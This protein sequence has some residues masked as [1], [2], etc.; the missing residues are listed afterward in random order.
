MKKLNNKWFVMLG[1]VVAVA[2]GEVTISA[3]EPPSPAPDVPT[4]VSADAENTGMGSASTVAVP[5]A[6]QFRAT[7][8]DNRNVILNKM[9]VITMLL[10]TS[11]DSQNAARLAGKEMY[12][13]QGRR[14]FRL[15]VVV[16][17]HDS[18]A[19]W[20]P[21][22]TLD[23]MRS[24][25]DKEA[26][27]LKPYY[28]M[29]GNKSNPRNASEVVADFSGAISSQLGWTS[30]SE[31]LR[32]I[33]FGADGREIKRWNKISDMDKLQ[34]DVRA[35]LDALVLAKHSHPGM[36]EGQSQPPVAL[37]VNPPPRS[38]QD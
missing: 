27:E 21:S 4:Q 14:D 7:D 23:Q 35:A 8:A 24:N 9:G 6:P 32:G 31:N 26:I 10:G 5:P 30:N 11:E 12:P 13:F 34:A 22:V 19:T 28:L 25:L 36:P 33:L 37:P 20:V 29:N 18:L 2:I 15:V 3:Q 16:D 17:L 38:N 1:V